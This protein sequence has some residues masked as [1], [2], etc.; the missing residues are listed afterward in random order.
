MLVAAEAED[1]LTSCLLQ[2]LAVLGM[3]LARQGTLGIA[4]T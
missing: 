2:L 1:G 3:E 4:N